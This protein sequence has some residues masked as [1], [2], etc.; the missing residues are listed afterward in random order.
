MKYSFNI[1]DKV[2]LTTIQYHDSE[3]NPIWNGI[4]GQIEGTISEIYEFVCGIRYRVLWDNN[5]ANSYYAEDLSLIKPV[6]ILLFNPV[7]MLL[8]EDLFTL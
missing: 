6:N 1:D 3:Y 7:N 2:K 8:N 4:H 5:I